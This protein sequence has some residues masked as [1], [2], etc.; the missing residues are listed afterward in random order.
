MN[1]ENSNNSVFF[2]HALISFQK[3]DPDQIGE[4]IVPVVPHM[5]KKKRT[6]IYSKTSISIVFF[7]G[8]FDSEK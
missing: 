2:D 4:I 3:S 6:P 8:S 7:E 1:N 5:N